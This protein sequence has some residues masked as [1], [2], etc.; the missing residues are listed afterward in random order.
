V[1]ADDTLWYYEGLAK[2]FCERLSNQ[3][4]DELLEIVDILQAEVAKAP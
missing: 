2:I 3:L 1:P 4:S